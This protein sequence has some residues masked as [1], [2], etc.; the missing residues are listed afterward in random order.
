SVD[1]GIDQIVKALEY[2]GDL[3]NSVLIFTSDNGFYFGE[4]RIARDK[5]HPYEEGLRVPLAMRV[6]QRFLGGRPIVPQVSQQVAN[7]DLA[8][9]LLE[10]AGG[11]PC[12][13]SG[14]CRVM[15]GRSLMPLLRG[16]QGWPS[17][18]GLLVEYDGAGSKGTS[19]CRYDGIRTPAYFY[20]EHLAVPDPLTGG[21]RETEEFELYDL[22]ADPFQLQNLYSSDG[23][24][25]G[26]L[27]DRLARLRD[28]NGIEGRDPLPDDVSHCE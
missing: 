22:R 10:L 4:H 23:S 28:C 7:I 25:V 27:E 26:Q 21:C 1:R 2:T 18:R 9:T 11:E 8:P 17:S 24:T 12:G 14:D 6:P 20:V 13:G 5:T 19:S 3:Q 16:E 15:D